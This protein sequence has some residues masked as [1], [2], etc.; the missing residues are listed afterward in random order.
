MSNVRHLCKECGVGDITDDQKAFSMLDDGDTILV[1][2]ECYFSLGG[3]EDNDRPPNTSCN[4]TWNYS[5]ERHNIVM[6]P[7]LR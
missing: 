6:R 3:T 4:D 1:C 7:S 2:M 5:A